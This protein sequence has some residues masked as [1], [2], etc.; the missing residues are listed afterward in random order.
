MNMKHYMTALILFAAAASSC[1]ENEW[2]ENTGNDARTPV[3]V[4][5]MAVSNGESD[6]QNRATASNTGKFVW[7]ESDMV[8]VTATPIA[9]TAPAGAKTYTAAYTYNIVAGQTVGTWTVAT[10]TG[11]EGNTPIYLED[12]DTQDDGGNATYTFTAETWGGKARPKDNTDANGNAVLMEEQNTT[13]LYTLS[14]YIYGPATLVLT[15]NGAVGTITANG[16]STIEG[17]GEKNILTHRTVDMI[18]TLNKGNGWGDDLTTSNTSFI[19]HMKNIATDKNFKLYAAN[20]YSVVPIMITDSDGDGKEDTDKEG[21]TLVT[22]RAHI[23]AS[24]LPGASAGE[25]NVPLLSIVPPP[26][27][28]QSVP[29]VITA[30]YNRPAEVVDGKSLQVSLTYSYLAGLSNVSATVGE[31]K[32]AENLPVTDGGEQTLTDYDLIINTPEDLATFAHAVNTGAEIINQHT[33]LPVAA[34]KAK[35]IQLAELDMQKL[36]T[37]SEQYEATADNWI[38][39]GTE[40]HPFKGEYVAQDTIRNLK[41]SNAANLIYSGLF[42]YVESATLLGIQ[43]QNCNL[44]ITRDDAL[45]ISAGALAGQVAAAMVSQCGAGGKLTIQQCKSTNIGGLIGQATDVSSISLCRAS[46]DIEMSGET[47]DHT[48]GGLTG[49]MDASYLVSC[50]TDHSINVTGTTIQVGGL[51]GGNYNGLL[52]TSYTA[53]SITGSAK[54][55]LKAGGIAGVNNGSLG[56]SYSYGEMNLK[57]TAQQVKAGAIAGYHNPQNQLINCFGGCIPAITEDDMD[58]NNKQGIGTSNVTAIEDDIEYA[59]GNEPSEGYVY[60]ILTIEAWTINGVPQPSGT[61]NWYA[62]KAWK[63]DLKSIWPVLDPKYRGTN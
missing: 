13:E 32:P 58:I 26:L 53:V 60:A 61:T 3:V 24:A 51:V 29:S 30:T 8:Q 39:I 4:S 17:S 7:Q 46:M 1:S 52:F 33:L 40:K 59:D 10:G 56:S 47:G 2:L 25:E 55:A 28:G 43:L 9:A 54:G 37:N 63:K 44:T 18:I 38:P 41:I 45:T 15:E 6:P 21:N 34:A 22:L 42:G 23:P 19:K 5:G 27:Q 36:A 62:Q 14:D 20:G 31:W 12:I 16:Q 35:V 49:Y 50:F 11:Y 48:I 57:G